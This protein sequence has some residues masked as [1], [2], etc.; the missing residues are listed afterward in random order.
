MKKCPFCAEE[1]QEEAIKCKHCKLDLTKEVIKKKP[2]IDPVALWIKIIVYPCFI[3]AGIYYWKIG[4]PVFLFWYIWKQLKLDKKKRIV[5]SI[6]LA[7]F[8]IPLLSILAYQGRTPIIK[9]TEPEDNFLTQA[10]TIEIKGEIKPKNSS[11][12]VLDNNGQSSVGLNLNEGR[13]VYQAKLSD[14]NNIFN[15]NG[16]N[17]KK[18]ASKS[19]TIKRILTEEERAKIEAQKQAALEAQAKAQAEAEAQ[20]KAEQA[21]YERTKAGKL[22]KAHPLWT[23]EECQN[24]ADN[25]YWIGM[26]IDMLKEERGTPNSANPSNYGY[27]TSWQWCWWDYTPSCFYGENNGIITSYN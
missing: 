16:V 1:I 10:Q 23:K 11:L 20:A 15:F 22:C 8:W 14:E 13:F 26:T 7:L 17:H 9:I 6:A 25:K 21:A 12:S 5:I 3:L 18:T 19:I 4:V 24:I 27:G 2:T